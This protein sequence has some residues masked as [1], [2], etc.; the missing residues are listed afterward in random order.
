MRYTQARSKLQ[1]S[2]CITVPIHF[3][4]NSVISRFAILLTSA[5]SSLYT[6]SPELTA[7]PASQP[8]ST[9]TESLIPNGSAHAEDSTSQP[10]SHQL[11]QQSPPHADRKRTERSQVWRSSAANSGE[12]LRGWES[13]SG[14]ALVNSAGCSALE[15]DNSSATFWAWW[16]L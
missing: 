3:Q 2:V 15:G 10:P 7:D 1:R 16:G 12:D 14:G 8:P 11:H 9:Q 6:S 13:C 4:V 5:S